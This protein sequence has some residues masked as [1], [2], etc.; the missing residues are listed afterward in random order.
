MASVLDNLNRAQHIRSLLEELLK[1]LSIE[2]W[3]YDDGGVM[4]AGGDYRWPVCLNSVGL[5]VLPSLD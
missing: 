5:A 3:N 4:W 1:H 2:R